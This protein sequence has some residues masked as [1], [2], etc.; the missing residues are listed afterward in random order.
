MKRITAPLLISFFL[1]GGTTLPGQ[2]PFD[3]G[4]LSS[5]V[6]F[7]KSNKTVSNKRLAKL[8]KELGVDFEPN[9]S[10][11]DGLRRDGAKDA[12]LKALRSA[13]KADQAGSGGQ[14]IRSVYGVG[15]EAI[16][17]V[18]IYKPE[19]PYS[20]RARRANLN[21]VL[22][23]WVVIGPRGNVIDIKEVS[24]PVGE[25][26]DESAIGTVSTWKF[27]PP[28]RDGAPVAVHT[29]IEVSFRTF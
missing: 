5:L 4:D 22:V 16:P 6:K 18:P 17:L 8:V 3:Q 13:K 28:T 9:D 12:L 10:Y 23:L 1:L 21:G 27:E 14:S 2:S 20:E 29:H 25:G 7:A 19:P 24:D 11:L 15:S 26:L